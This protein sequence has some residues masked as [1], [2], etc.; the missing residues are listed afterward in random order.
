MFAPVVWAG[1]IPNPEGGPQTGTP[2]LPPISSPSLDWLVPIALFAAIFGFAMLV[3][4]FKLRQSRMLHET[5]RLTIEKGQ[6][7]PPDLLRLGASNPSSNRDLRYGLVCIALGLGL[8]GYGYGSQE[9][10]WTVG[11]IPFLIGVAF[12][13]T[14]KFE[15]SRN[16]R[17]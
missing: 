14:W 4:F 3:V 5:L 13:I 15:S 6:P 17:S 9:A 7:I 10:P 2:S 16:G 12:L 8:A 1:A 11:L